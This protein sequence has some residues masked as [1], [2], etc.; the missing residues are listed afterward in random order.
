MDSGRHRELGHKGHDLPRV[1]AGLL[2]MMVSGK[3]T[4]RGFDVLGMKWACWFDILGETCLLVV[5]RFS[6]GDSKSD[7]EVSLRHTS[8]RAALA[9]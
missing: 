1:G 3:V 8:S 9:A 6:W 5:V 2:T 4:R 7:F